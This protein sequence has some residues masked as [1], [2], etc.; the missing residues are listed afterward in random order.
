MV[1]EHVHFTAEN[2][3]AAAAPVLTGARQC[4]VD[5]SSTRDKLL[6]SVDAMSYSAAASVP[7]DEEHEKIVGFYVA[8]KRTTMIPTMRPS[9]ASISP[10]VLC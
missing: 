10:V 2:A 4:R 8:D 3:N 5:V 1:I 6:A 9:I 7:G